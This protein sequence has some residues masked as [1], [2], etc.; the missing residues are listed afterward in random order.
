[1]RSALA[2][3]GMTERSIQAAVGSHYRGSAFYRR[4]PSRP[5]VQRVAD[6]LG[7]QGLA[8]LATNDV[9]WDR[10]VEVEPLGE[11]PVFDATVP[12]THNFAANSIFAHNSIEQDSDLVM[13]LWREKERGEEDGGVDEEGEVV[14]LSLAKHR[15]GPTG[16]MKLWFKKRQT[17]FVQLE[18]DRVPAYG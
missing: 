2:A 13:F 12:G 17:R 1:V 14:N 8:D 16:H 6:V 7:D 4:P 10:V 5:R 15:N 11:Q 9:F 18:E 3:A